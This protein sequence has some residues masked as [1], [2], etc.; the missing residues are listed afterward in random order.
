MGKLA[1]AVEGGAPPKGHWCPACVFLDGLDPETRQEAQQMVDDR[2]WYPM[3]IAEVWQQ[4]GFEGTNKDIDV[5]RKSVRA[6]G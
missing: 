5:H 6:H 2:N 3:A 4:I 1:K